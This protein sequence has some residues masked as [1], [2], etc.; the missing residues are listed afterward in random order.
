MKQDKGVSNVK[1]CNISEVKP[2]FRKFDGTSVR[3]ID[4]GDD[5]ILHAIDFM[6]SLIERKDRELQKLSKVKKYLI[7]EYE[8][9]QGS[10]IVTPCNKESNIYVRSYADVSE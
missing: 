10:H 8:L 5:E 9:R 7:L 4:M 2:E 6:E 1:D 3:I